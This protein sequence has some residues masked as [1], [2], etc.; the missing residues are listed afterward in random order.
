MRIT[1]STEPFSTLIAALVLAAPA[2]AA[3]QTTGTVAMTDA[4]TTLEE[5]R[6]TATP[7]RR[8]VLKTAQPVLVIDGDELL[9][10]RSTTIAE[11]LADEPGITASNFGP[12]ASRPIIRGQGGLRVQV[13]QD[14]A[15]VLDAAALSED[16]A[17]TLDP[18]LAERIEVVRG[19]AALLFGNSASAGAVNVVT[20][21]LPI[22]ALDRPFAAALELR[23]DSAAD[24]RAVGAHAAAKVGDR[25]QVYADLHDSRSDDLRI[26]GYA[27]T[28][29]AEEYFEAEGEPADES[30]DRLTNSDG[31]ADGGSLGIAWVGERQRYGFSVSEYGS[32]YGL[33]GLGEDPGEPPDVRLDMNQRRYDAVAEWSP[34]S[35]AV[36]ALRLRAARNDYEHVEIEGNG[37]IGTRYAQVGDEVR[38]TAEHGVGQGRGVFG[39]HWRE[40]DF[41]AKGEEAFLPP[42]TTRNTGFFAFQEHRLG[43]VT[44]EAGAR[45]ERQHIRTADPDTLP[46]YEGSTLSGSVG[47]L[48]ALR[49]GA[50][51]ALQLTRSERHPTATEL[52]A[53]G[54]HLA[55]GR[56]EIGD[57]DLDTERGL[58]AD[59]ALR[60]SGDAGWRG[61]VG[62]FIG[63]YDRHIVAQTTGE[64]EDGLPVIEFESRDARFTGAEF[65]IGHDAL[66]TTGV[67]AL[68]LRL[69]GDL[70]RAEDGAGTPL[71]HIP[72]LRL[73]AEA[74]L[75][76][77][78]LRLGLEAIWHDSQDRIAD[79]ER[80]TEGYT[81]LN[82]EASWRQPVGAAG[83]SVFL[84]GSNLLD[85]EARRHVSPLKDYAPLAGRAISGGLRLEF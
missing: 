15:D 8:T 78:R 73:G 51:L 5:V 24:T 20:R 77:T 54:P 43:E 1:T 56:Y 63:D 11:T 13:F 19:P 84:R 39:L 68:G 30:R 25:V 65:E 23:G 74:S 76:G 37:E 75:T 7:L 58:T 59:L 12:I 79:G 53:D 35:G 41:D 4:R 46:S 57:A 33:P 21:R 31:S 32:E 40:L 29:T 52:Y 72:P 82:L 69:F 47:A 28:E 66:T 36:D 80:R 60:L 27:W 50:T 49:P 3:A 17:V 61:S 81:M 10:G 2:L 42:S 85:E 14:G 44:L 26:P 48:W 9:R 64:I 62:V 16:H 18:L 83:L 38:L 71:P 22:E 55:V 45:Y 6:I 70:V 67:G 34:S